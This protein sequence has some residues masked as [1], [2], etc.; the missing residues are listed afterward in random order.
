MLCR[1][2]EGFAGVVT[3]AGR[4]GGAWCPSGALARVRGGTGQCDLQEEDSSIRPGSLLDLV[5]A[6]V[7]VG[8]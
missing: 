6:C 3:S 1:G 8:G 2:E 7:C 5:S 4:G